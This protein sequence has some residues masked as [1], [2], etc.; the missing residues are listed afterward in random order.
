M[1]EAGH[2]NIEEDRRGSVSEGLFRVHLRRLQL[3]SSRR[4]LI[5]L[6]SAAERQTN[7][8]IGPLQSTE[9]LA[10][11]RQRT[12]VSLRSFVASFLVRDRTTFL[13]LHEFERPRDGTKCVS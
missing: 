7:P 6:Q 9:L 5:F 12:I 4:P 13:P 1:P 8:F 10:G 2:E 11:E 3:Q